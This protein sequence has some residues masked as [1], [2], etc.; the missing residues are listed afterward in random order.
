MNVKLRSE[1]IA[2]MQKKLEKDI[3]IALRNNSKKPKK[4]KTVKQTV[5][6]EIEEENETGYMKYWKLYK[7]FLEKKEFVFKPSVR[8]NSK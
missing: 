4:E 3:E 2:Q 7:N 5:E 1:L 6:N 8:K